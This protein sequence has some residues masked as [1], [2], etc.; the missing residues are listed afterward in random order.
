ME[1]EP[2]SPILTPTTDTPVAAVM[3]QVQALTNGFSGPEMLELS[4][5]LAAGFSRAETLDLTATLMA[6]VMTGLDS[7]LRS[8]DELLTLLGSMEAVGRLSDAGRVALAADVDARS[9]SRTQNESLARKRGCATGTDLISL[10]TRVSAR[11]AKRR[12][13]LGAKTRT[14]QM[15]GSVLP[16]RYPVVAAALTAGAIGV[17]A[18][19]AIVTGLSDLPSFLAPADVD[20]A[21][22]GLVA[23]ATGTI[24]AENEGLPNAGFA[25]PAD[26]IRGRN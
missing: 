9:D 22:R 4:A 2:V 19:E 12:S 10:L 6:G 7:H 13:K 14:F 17:D 11:E 15:V 3:A 16:P 21:E 8:D 20:A 18:A 1:S 5:T 24:T 25:F 23:S 26:L